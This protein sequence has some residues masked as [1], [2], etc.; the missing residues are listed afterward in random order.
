MLSYLKI[1]GTPFEAGAALG[2][3][4]AKAV[5]QYLKNTASWASI[6]RW[7][8]SQRVQAMASLVQSRHPEYWQELQGLAA[9]LEMPLDDMF[10]WNCRGDLWAM[11][12]D[13]CTTVQL[14]GA[15]YPLFAHNEDGDPGFA[16]Q[17]AIAE[18]AVVGGG[19]FASFVYP[20][21]LP[22]H[23]FAVTDDGLAMTVNNLRALH[24]DAGL[25]RMVLVRSILDLPNVQSA[26]RYLKEAPRSG[27]FH[28]T[29]AQAGSTE[30][31]SVEFS[32]NLCSVVKLEKPS[33]H[34]NHMI[35]PA[36]A[37]QPQII[38]GSS[39]F[40]QIRG[41]E[42]LG[43]AAASGAPPKP[44]AIL[45]DQGNT[46]FPIY[47]NDPR[48]SDNE[49]TMASASIQVRADCIEWQVHAGQS[50]VPLFCMTNGAK[51]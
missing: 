26:V 39:G 51:L 18:I 43:Q 44:L 49:N 1:K 40:R 29:L 37:N 42:L 22:G 8:G 47:R 14:P 33:L 9:G 46:Q 15:E 16:G 2:R 12:V 35:H 28:L 45:F 3:F 13:G 17:C 24:V 27:G 5:Q 41:E 19:R 4:G 11:S 23:T 48:D 7:R 30:L 38:T 34:A 36:M 6:M 32:A 21:S 31:L 10:L 50:T 25:P 20:G